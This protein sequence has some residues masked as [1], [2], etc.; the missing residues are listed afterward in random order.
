MDCNGAIDKWHAA[1]KA[2]D[3]EKMLANLGKLHLKACQLEEIPPSVLKAPLTELEIGENKISDFA[4]LSALKSLRWLDVTGDSRAGAQYTAAALATLPDLP[5]LQTL[6]LYGND[7]PAIPDVVLKYPTLTDLNICHNKVIKIPPEMP[8]QQFTKM[9][10]LNLSSNKI[11]QIPPSIGTLAS[12]RVLKLQMNRIVRLPALDAMVA[13]TTV[14]LQGNSLLEFP[15]FGVHPDLT[16]INVTR[17]QLEK[18]APFDPACFPNLETLELEGN[19]LKELPGALGALKKLQ[20]LNA[21]A[22]AIETVA[23]EVFHTGTP[24]KVLMLQNNQLTSL[25][26]SIGCCSEL[27]TLLLL[28]NKLA[29]LPHSLGGVKSLARVSL[30]EN[31]L[32]DAARDTVAAVRANVFAHDEKARKWDIA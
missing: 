27:M 21:D 9:E 14:H 23:P 17:N 15:T 7:L 32:G 22:N 28:G 31:P 12:L 16:E 25:P 8:F 11:M 19:R 2:P 5:H 1:L 24:L 6:H 20:K 10:E 26:D 30:K 4:P 3:R 13:L 18:L 29:A